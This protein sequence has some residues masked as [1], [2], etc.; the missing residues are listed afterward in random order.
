MFDSTLL[1]K[2]TD[3]A[4]AIIISEVEVFWRRLIRHL[5]ETRYRLVRGYCRTEDAVRY[6]SGPEDEAE[7]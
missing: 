5:R 2:L 3:L 1:S 7:G 6:A 4:M